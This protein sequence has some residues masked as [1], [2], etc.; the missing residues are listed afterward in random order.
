MVN[1]S[2]LIGVKLPLQTVRHTCHVCHEPFL[3]RF[4]GHYL[5]DQL[6]P[7]DW[8]C[9]QCFPKWLLSHEAM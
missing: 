7:V 3:Y 6:H 1:E 5:K 4:D 8:I 9:R 2:T